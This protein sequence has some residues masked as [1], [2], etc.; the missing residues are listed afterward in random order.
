MS[1][2][3]LIY[4]IV[5]RDR[6]SSAEKDRVFKGA[7]IDLQD[8]FIHFSAAGQ[9]AETLNKHFAGQSDLLL[10]AVDPAAL[11]DSLKWEPSRGGEKFPHLY[12]PLALEKVSFVE[13]ILLD[14]AGNHQFSLPSIE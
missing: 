4:K 3:R 11:G 1:S 6:W 9:V 7:E 2:E 5:H 12:G 14:E 8:G 10:V 13:E